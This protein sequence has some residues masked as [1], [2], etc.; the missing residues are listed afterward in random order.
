M[1]GDHVLGKS[2]VIS[3]VNSIHEAKKEADTGMSGEKGNL[4][5]GHSKGS[6]MGKEVEVEEE[7][8]GEV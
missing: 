5:M 2:G 4:A 7:A 6:H 1:F 8:E 3:P